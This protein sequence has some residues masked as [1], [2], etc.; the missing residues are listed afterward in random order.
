ME[1]KQRADLVDLVIVGAGPAGLTAALYASRA[2]LSVTVLEGMMAGGK[3]FNT[4]EVE[5]WIG[6]KL[7]SGA[8]LANRMIEHAFSLGAV[9]EY[10]QVEQIRDMGDY[11]EVETFDRIFPGKTVLIASGTVERKLGIPGEAEYYGLGISYCAVCDAAFYKDKVVVVVGGGNTAFEDADYL[12]RFAKEVHLVL[13]RDKARAEKIL[14][15]R[16]AKN[17]KIKIHLQYKPT[18][19]H[20]ENGKVSAVD[21]VSTVEGNEERMTIPCDGIFP[22]VGVDPNSAFAKDLGIL[23][24]AGY[25]L[26]KEDMSTSVSGIYA[27]GDCRQKQLRQIVTAGS[28]GAIAAQAISNWLDSQAD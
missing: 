28:D 3:L 24:E 8:D 7:I 15:E 18:E 11:K 1:E 2:G 4:N 16:V 12:T 9:Q 25:I 26:T 6:D 14:Q 10:G 13:R 5:N 27:A 23:D 22:L 21:F 20:G 17:E 19:I